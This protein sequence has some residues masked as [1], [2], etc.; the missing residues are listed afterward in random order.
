MD[1]LH[2]DGLDAQCVNAELMLR[3]GP[4]GEFRV[5][6]FVDNRFMG[7]DASPQTTPPLSRSSSLGKARGLSLPSWMEIF[8]EWDVVE[9]PVHAL[10]FS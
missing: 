3:V 10:H 5:D 7:E 6:G 1:A 8:P 2:G 9:L 4:G